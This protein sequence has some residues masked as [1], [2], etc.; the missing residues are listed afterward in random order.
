[1]TQ[2]EREN[3]EQGEAITRELHNYEAEL[4]RDERMNNAGIAMTNATTKGW[5]FRQQKSDERGIKH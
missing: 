2:R 3:D 5:D 4:G 1:M